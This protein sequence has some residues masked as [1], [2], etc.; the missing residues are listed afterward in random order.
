MAFSI[1]KSISAGPFRFNLSKSGLGLSV[2]VKGLR[3]GT[4]PC[5]HYI[6]AGSAGFRYRATI[7]PKIGQGQV[8]KQSSNLVPKVSRRELVGRVVMVEI[9][10]GDVLGMREERFQDLIEE[11][12]K[13]AS[14]IQMSILLGVLGLFFGFIV[15]AT[16]QPQLAPI[17]FLLSV[18]MYFLGWWVDSFKRVAVLFYDFDP[19]AEEKFQTL[20]SAFKNLSKSQRVW[21]IPAGG[22]VHDLTTWKRNA[23]AAHLLR[24]VAISLGL[25]LPKIV[26]CNVDVPCVPVGAQNLYFFPDFLLVQSRG[27]VGAVG[28]DNLSIRTEPSNFVEEEYVPSDTQILYKTWKHPNKDGGPDRRFKDNRQIP[29]CQYEVIHFS[30]GSGVNE[31]VQV[32]HFGRGADFAKAVAVLG[33]IPRSAPVALI[34]DQGAS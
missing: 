30:S 21:H 8:A 24:R 15:L 11:I 3:F 22:T 29:V 14:Q 5:G 19:G 26:R 25:G 9:D 7:D 13:K 32:S 27:R 1:R 31:L 16:S 12:N 6:H 4:G 33:K 28:Y 34:G 18:G 2:G 20:L 10:S 17:A 23:G